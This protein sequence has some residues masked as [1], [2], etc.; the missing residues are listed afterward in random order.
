MRFAIEVA[1]LVRA[2]WPADRPVF[3]RIS[4]EDES[5]P[6][7]GL[8]EAVTLSVELKNLGVDVVDCSSGG[9]G[10]A[11]FAIRGRRIPGYQVGLAA[12]VRRRAG[13]QTMGVGLITRAAQAEGYLQSGQ[14][15][16]VAIARQALYDPNWA[17][18]AARELG[19]DP[20][21]DLWPIQHGWW[22]DYRA[23]TVLPETTTE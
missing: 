19:A 2:E 4:A 9:I 20:N 16:L 13:V 22:L 6:S 21:F 12:E 10:T 5:D 3:F 23:K 17:G 8:D 14:C 15:D 11:G 7:W 1:E 18:H